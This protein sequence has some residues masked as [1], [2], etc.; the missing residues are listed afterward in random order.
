M[1]S[2]HWMRRHKVHRHRKS[3]HNAIMWG[4]VFVVVAV[5][6]LLLWRYHTI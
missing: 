2:R 4:T 5:T 3:D 6:G 1:R